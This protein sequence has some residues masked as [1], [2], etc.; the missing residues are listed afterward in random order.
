MA[1]YEGITTVNLIAGEDLRD[2][3]NLLLRINGEGRAIK[4]TVG[5]DIAV[6]ILAENP[7]S[8]EDT[9]GNG[10]PVVLLGGIIKVV[11]GASHTVAAGSFVFAS[12]TDPGH[13]DGS[14]NLGAGV[15]SVGKALETG[16]NGDTFNV[17]SY[18]LLG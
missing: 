9:T 8:S 4:T 1:I 10:V 3:K 11:A 17:I 13:V 2:S 7:S 15:L 5:T 12:S 18:A 16:V 6:G 14:I